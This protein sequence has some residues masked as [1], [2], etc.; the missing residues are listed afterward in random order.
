[1]QV[2]SFPPLVRADARCLI[3]GTMPGEASLAA[4]RYYAH[5]RNAFWK[6]LTAILG[7]DVTA[8]H[9]VRCRAL[10][11]AKLALWD[12]LAACVREGSLDASIDKNTEV[13]NDVSGLIERCPCLTHV[14]F[15]G[16]K[17]EG[18][19]L[20]HIAASLRAGREIRTVRL[21]ST[22]PAHAGMSFAKKLEVWRGAIGPVLG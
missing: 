13:P 4:G 17:A 6:I 11:D 14:F 9:D 15:N 16:A 3:L 18:L 22:S 20:R 7:I 12:V 5:P 2:R 19:F 1:M 10:I 8:D 21:P